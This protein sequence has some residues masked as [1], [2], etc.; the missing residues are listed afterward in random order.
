MRCKCGRE[1][2]RYN[3]FEEDETETK[4]I[5]YCRTCKKW[6]SYRRY[7]EVDNRYYV[8]QIVASGTRRGCTVCG[9]VKDKGVK[10]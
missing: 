7:M 4:E 10:K 1:M 5:W 6:V 8:K 9:D 2:T 3:N